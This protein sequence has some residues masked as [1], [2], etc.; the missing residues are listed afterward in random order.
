MVDFTKE[1][2]GC[3][4]VFLNG[5]LIGPQGRLISSISTIIHWSPKHFQI[6]TGREEEGT[7]QKEEVGHREK[8]RGDTQS[9]TTMMLQSPQRRKENERYVQTKTNNQPEWQGV[10]ANNN[11]NKTCRE[12]WM[13]A[14]T[15]RKTWDT[16]AQE[17]ITFKEWHAFFMGLST[18]F[19]S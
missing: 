2:F 1:L 16:T 7:E 18:V 13:D 14:I 10:T 11:T 12:N 17:A 15:G 3:L 5:L 8:K 6:R 4:N 9:N 19:R